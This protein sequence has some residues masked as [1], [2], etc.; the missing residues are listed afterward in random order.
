MNKLRESLFLIFT[1]IT[2]ALLGM[3]FVECFYR[4]YK[5]NNHN[6]SVTMTNDVTHYPRP[7][8]VSAGK[9]GEIFFDEKFNFLGYRRFPQPYKGENEF[10]LVLLGGSTIA[11]G[12]APISSF[13]ED[14]LRSQGFTNVKVYNLGAVSSVSR[15]DILRI[16]IDLSGYLPDLII[17]YGGGNDL[18]MGTDKR[19]NFPHRFIHYEINQFLTKSTSDYDWFL[20][21]A[22]GS[23]FLRDQQ[24]IQSLVQKRMEEKVRI[25]V[26]PDSEIEHLRVQAYLENM[27]WGNILSEKIGAKFISVFQP[28]L[29]FKGFISTEEAKYISSSVKSYGKMQR[30]IYYS[31]KTKF[32]KDF[33]IIDCSNVFNEIRDTVFTDYM[34]II[35]KANIYPARCILDYLIKN[36]YLLKHKNLDRNFTPEEFYYF[37]YPKNLEN[38]EFL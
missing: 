21:L 10:R 9:P 12:F 14:E 1:A 29:S 4:F 17:H 23:S 20:G 24:L 26:P 28:V 7:Y 16:L 13:L 36:D 8:V 35:D 27:K 32:E 38:N 11:N 15:Q 37:G 2:F 31:K 3:L 5:K 18:V 25:F 33:R 6:P 30:D 19:L 34:H 22:M